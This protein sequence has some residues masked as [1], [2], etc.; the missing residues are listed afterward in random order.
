MA[1]LRPL[2]PLSAK[3]PTNSINLGSYHIDS[4]KYIGIILLII[5]LLVCSGYL[6]YYISKH[7]K[8]KK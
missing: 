8:R 5:I 2:R 1:R 6:Y 4:H 7:N 3:I